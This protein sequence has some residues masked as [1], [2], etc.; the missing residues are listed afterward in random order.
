MYIL[1]NSCSIIH[2]RNSQARSA[3][4]FPADYA[5]LIPQ[6]RQSTL[7]SAA[8]ATLT[9]PF[10]MQP[11]ADQVRLLHRTTIALSQ[12]HRL[13]QQATDILSN[14]HSFYLVHTQQVDP[15]FHRPFPTLPPAPL[16]AVPIPSP[17]SSCDSAPAAPIK[18][19]PPKSPPS[20]AS[21]A[22]SSS[23]PLPQPKRKRQPP[24]PLNEDADWDAWDADADVRLVELKTD[25]RL[26]PNWNYV[27]R[28]VGFS[29]EQCK[30]RWEEL[31]APQHQRNAIHPPPS[32]TPT[33]PANTPPASPAQMLP[34]QQRFHHWHHLQP[35]T[36]PTHLQHLHRL[37]GLP[38]SQLTPCQKSS[39]R[40]V[41]RN[42]QRLTSVAILYSFGLTQLSSARHQQ[43]MSM[44]CRTIEYFEFSSFLMHVTTLS[45]CFSVFA[46]SEIF[47]C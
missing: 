12:L 31:Q 30:A 29:I 25:A 22:S 23:P 45:S 27:A 33:S 3:C 38:Q 26:R 20:Q 5:A 37:H 14:L 39:V 10:Q 34:R 9:R 44:H 41:I 36:S 32:P 16:T 8:F 1:Q 47:G 11:H 24:P 17:T 42:S 40:T 18:H 2:L 43:T 35:Q 46:I 6:L 28:R 4:Y 21:S 13:L 7:Q 19:A 15:Q